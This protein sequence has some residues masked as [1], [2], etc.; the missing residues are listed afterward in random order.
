MRLAIVVV[1]VV[2]AVILACGAINIGGAPIFGH[3]DEVAGTYFF[4]AIYNNIFFFLHRGE[5]SVTSGLEKTETEIEE[6]S[7]RPAGIDNSRKYRQ[8]D[9]AAAEY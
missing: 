5:D 9:K 3:M 2:L 7:K 1:G 8:L 6:F 4:M